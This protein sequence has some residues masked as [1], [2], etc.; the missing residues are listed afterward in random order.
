MTEGTERD[1]EAFSALIDG[2]LPSDERDR[3]LDRVSNDP[4]LRARWGRYHASRAAMRGALRQRLRP[5]FAQRVEEALE[6]E[7]VI[8]P[9]AARPGA[10]ARW[11]R[12][13]SVTAVAAVAALGVVAVAGVVLNRQAGV[14]DDPEPQ[15]AVAEPETTPLTPRAGA[16]DVPV[17]SPEGETAL[18]PT[19][20]AGGGASGEFG[21]G[22]RETVDEYLTSH[23]AV[24][25]SGEISE[26]IHSGR[27]AS[28][29]IEP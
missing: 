10:P 17:L 4:R 2:E 8:T 23:A 19:V 22:F 13:Q 25:A 27:V 15:V 9:P 11:P 1:D 20:A 28:H 29:R 5:G 14:S 7:P 21:P 12:A 26:L 18:T 16:F 24:S 3:I 6:A